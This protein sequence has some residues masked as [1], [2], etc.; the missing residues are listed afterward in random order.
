MTAAAEWIGGACPENAA[1]GAPAWGLEAGEVERRCAGLAR[2]AGPLRRAL[3]ALAG[4]FQALRGWERIGYARAGDYTRER[5]GRSA[6]ELS[7][8]TRV[9]TALR[10]LPRLEAALVFG[11]LPWTK[12]RLIARA[13]RPE[14]EAAWIAVARRIT[15]RQLECSVRAIDTGSVEGGGA[16]P[17][18]EDEGGREGVVMLLRPEIQAKWQFGW[19]LARRVAGENLDPGGAAEWIVAEVLSALPAVAEGDVEAP[20]GLTLQERR[21]TRWAQRYAPT[22][23]LQALFEKAADEANAD[24]RDPKAEAAALPAFLQGLVADLDSADAF[25]LDARL[26]RA[27]ALEQ[28][29]EAELGPLLYLVARERLYRLPGYAGLERYAAERLGIS[30]RK[31]WALLRIERARRR[32][33]GLLGAYRE[34]RIS[35]VQAQALVALVERAPAHA[36]AWIACASRVTVRRLRDEVDRALLLA[37]SDPEVFARDG[38]PSDLDAELACA[39]DAGARLQTGANPTDLEGT[40]LPGDSGD[41]VDPTPRETARAFFT[42]PRDVARL[43]RATL[44]TSQRRLGARLGRP[45]TL[46]DALDAVLEHCFEAWGV[47]NSKLARKRKRDY[48]IFERDGWICTV[49][50]CTSYRNLHVHHKHFRSHGGDDADDNRITLCAWH[51]QRGLHR[52]RV[53]RV[54]GRAR[55]RFELG[56]RRDRPPLAAYAKGDVLL[57]GSP[58]A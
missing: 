53:V 5:L 31:A 30:P 36:E 49:P 2:A 7:D 8:L 6:R 44:C 12:V 33:P 10:T 51:H 41:S 29:L 13:A 26:R 24:A 1:G 32:C 35:W 42:A 55:T 19:R 37:D 23:A 22:Q 39:S 56:V 15:V 48:R 38:G 45:A 14:T 50:G 3:A 54:V 47:R 17:E 40:L 57:S 34:G 16:E 21:R 46:S 4:R 18:A 9:D 28:R 27:V 52:D 58:Y 20:R 43:F 25:A 11:T